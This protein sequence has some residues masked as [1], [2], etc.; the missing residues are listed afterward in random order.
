[1]AQSKKLTASTFFKDSDGKVVLFQPPNFLLLGWIVF[2]LLALFVGESNIKNGCE[3]LGKAFLFTW[4]YLEIKNGVNYFRKL[5]G[6]IVISM[7]ILS[8]FWKP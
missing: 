6:L 3:Q 7:I 5:L 2:A 1:M 4:A 8:F